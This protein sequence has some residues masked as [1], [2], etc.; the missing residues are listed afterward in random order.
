MD[1]WTQLLPTSFERPHAK[2]L[3]LSRLVADDIFTNVK[4]GRNQLEKKFYMCC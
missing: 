1:T 3:F 2:Y 4:L